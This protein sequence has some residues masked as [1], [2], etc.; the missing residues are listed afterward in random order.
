MKYT[1]CQWNLTLSLRLLCWLFETD[2]YYELPA[3]AGIKNNADLNTG[4]RLWGGGGEF[5]LLY[6][7][8][9]CVKLLLHINQYFFSIPFSWFRTTSNT[10]CDFSAC[11]PFESLS[12]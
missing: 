12:T 10:L 1:H 7:S 4:E 5:L 8:F 2:F 6:I 11:K 9:V 3:D